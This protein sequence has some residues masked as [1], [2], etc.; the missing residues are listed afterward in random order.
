VS[1][2]QQVDVTSSTTHQKSALKRHFELPYIENKDQRQIHL[3]AK[4]QS[5]QDP[6]Q[7]KY[8]GTVVIWP[9]QQNPVRGH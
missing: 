6:H 9:M 3:A 4:Q 2:D 8:Q 7:K 1:T 5:K